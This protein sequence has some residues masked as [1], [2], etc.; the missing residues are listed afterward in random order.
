MSNLDQ[1]IFNL[2]QKL[3][4]IQKARLLAFVQ[5]ILGHLPANLNTRKSTYLNRRIEER[6]QKAQNSFG[7]IKMKAHIPL[8]SFRRENFYGDGQ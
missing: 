2:I 6:L 7:T 4:E 3:D 8:E 1:T 5:S